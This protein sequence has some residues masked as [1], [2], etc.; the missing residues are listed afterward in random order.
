MT[1]HR[2]HPFAAHQTKHFLIFGTGTEYPAYST[3]QEMFQHFF[4]IVTFISTKKMVQTG[5]DA[6]CT[7]PDKTVQ[8]IL[9]WMVTIFVC[10]DRKGSRDLFL[11]G[12]L[13]VSLKIE[14]KIFHISIRQSAGI[15][16]PPQVLY[17]V[18]PVSQ[19]IKPDGIP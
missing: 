8:H 16:A 7:V 13:I 11:T 17:N 3:Q 6:W 10:Y 9:N 18:Y 14:E 19:E 1:E 4:H 15:P 5:S 2:L 12:Q